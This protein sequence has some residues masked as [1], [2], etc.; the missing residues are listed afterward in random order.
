MIR[1]GVRTGH[2][3]YFTG[4]IGRNGGNIILGDKINL[5]NGITD[6]LAIFSDGNLGTILKLEK[7]PKNISG[8]VAVI[9]LG[10]VQGGGENLMAADGQLIA[11]VLG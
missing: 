9:K 7:S 5:R 11:D 10:A 4:Y 3:N 2:Q 1:I 8:I 6:G